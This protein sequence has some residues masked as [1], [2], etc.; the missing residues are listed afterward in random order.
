MGIG[1]FSKIP[2]GMP[3]VEHRLDLIFQGVEAGEIS[4]ARWV[5]VTSTTPA[6]LFGLFP[7]KGLIAPGADADVVLYDPNAT[8][9][10]SVETHHMNVDYSAYEGMK[11]KGK[12]TTVLSRG[13][14]IVENDE[15]IG[16]P[17]SGR[18]LKRGLN[19]LLR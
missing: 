10:I 9:T 6:R 1:N 13:Q 4:L 7:R 15:F 2:N 5:D 11:L 17:G 18:F 19:G 16:T 3:G 8:H 14:V 12:A